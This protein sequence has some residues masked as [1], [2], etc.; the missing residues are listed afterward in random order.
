MWADLR[1]GASARVAGM[2][3][4]HFRRRSISRGALR[5][6][7]VRLL[8]TVLVTAL[9][10]V[11]CVVAYLFLR[12]VSDD[13][14]AWSVL[15]AVSTVSAVTWTQAA[16]LI[17]RVL[18]QGSR[19]LLR[20][21]ASLPVTPRER[22][23]ALMLYEMGTVL[24]LCTAGF[25]TVTVASL[26]LTRGRTLPMLLTAVVIPIVLVY[27]LLN[28]VT[29]LTER[30]F[31]SIGLARL[32]GTLTV[33]VLFGLTVGFATFSPM[34]VIEATRQPEGFRGVNLVAWGLSTHPAVALPTLAAVIVLLVGAGLVLAPREYAAPANFSPF[35]VPFPRVDSGWFGYV[36]FTLRSTQT[37]LSMV[38]ATAVF[39]LLMVR[40]QVHPAS[41]MYLLSL[42]GLYL[43]GGTE[44]L[45]SSGL[46][47]GRPW[48]TYVRI[49]GAQLVLLAPA[50]VCAA[51]VATVVHPRLLAELPGLL[52]GAASSVIITSLVG[53]AFPASD[54][55]P[56]SLLI[57]LTVLALGAAGAFVTVGVLQLPTPIAV[58]LAVVAH[59]TMVLHS[60][61]SIT[62]TERRN[63]HEDSDSRHELPLDRARRDVGDRRRHGACAHVRVR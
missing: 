7:G 23:V 51:G 47:D 56:F 6:R 9:L 46:V 44:G 12:R 27:L 35:P 14:R 31:A 13:P 48:R 33:L 39:V 62:T 55:N 24:I 19:G 37:V 18:F 16:H 50:L 4:T 42:P 21:T 30:G 53:C 41:A 29:Q 61:F 17:V 60:V 5:S 38:I 36:A 25:L 10:S 11:G 26:A 8:L 49:V 20:S 32:R 15:F 43:Y 40:P 3:F 45:R 63:R 54:D 34:L 52:A 2:L 59:G 58:G 1:L 28:I 57:G 22:S